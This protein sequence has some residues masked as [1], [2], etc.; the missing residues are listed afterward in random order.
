MTESQKPNNLKVFGSR[1]TKG[2][3]QD[4]LKCVEDL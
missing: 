2:P 4:M 3:K 1:K